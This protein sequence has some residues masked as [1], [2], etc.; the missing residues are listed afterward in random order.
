MHIEAKNFTIFVKSVL[1]D[2]FKN[3]LVLDVGGGD[4]NGN[5]RFLFKD[6]TIHV[7]DVCQSSNV[8][9]ISRTK[10][11]PFKNNT[12]DTI[13]STE[14]FEHD[15]EYKD[16]I[17]KIYDMLKPD[18]LFLFTCASTGRMEHG[19]RKTSPQDSYGSIVGENDMQDYYKNLTKENII[20]IFDI[21][22]IFKQYEFYYNES[23]KDLYFWGIKCGN[24]ENQPISLVSI[25]TFK[26]SF[27]IKTGNSHFYMNLSKDDMT[28]LCNQMY[29][30][31]GCIEYCIMNNIKKLVVS[32][33]LKEIKTDDKC[34][35]SEVIDIK[36]INIFLMNYGIQIIDVDERLYTN[37]DF[38]ISP[39]LYMGCS[40]NNILYKNILNNICFLEFYSNIAK[41]HIYSNEINVI[42]LRLEE[43][44]L[45]IFSR[46]IGIHKDV[47]K[48]I[49]EQRYIDRI[50][51]YIDKS[52]MTIV[53]GS[54]NNRVVDFLREN[55]Y[56]FMTTNKMFDKREINAVIDLN[57]GFECNKVFIGSF[58][59]TFSYTI[60]C[61]LL[62][63]D[64]FCCLIDMNKYIDSYKI[65]K[66]EK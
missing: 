18:G 22:K 46:E 45:D 66:N 35:L 51:E 37:T 26:D 17:L 62:K 5:N 30:L 53:I 50:K 54:K 42:H 2:Y 48:V 20:E 57:I 25:P 64:V 1:P 36:K 7:N 11:L 65:Y 33:L 24:Y 39:I 31:T 15:P 52:I 60:M 4:I 13:I 3:K 9:I 16:S 32:R 56:I 28:G 23:S 49:N 29:A 63:K 27:V 41:K 19:T 14:C 59:S 40:K 47:Y 55:K 12:F 21:D 44:A 43:D 38:L 61:R 34:L 8:T 10:N 6:C 58:D